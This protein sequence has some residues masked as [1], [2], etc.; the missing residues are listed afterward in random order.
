MLLY[1]DNVKMLTYSGTQLS[2]F[3]RGLFPLTVLHQTV[4]FVL[5]VD[6]TQYSF[7][8]YVFIVSIIET[9]KTDV[10]WAW[11]ATWKKTPIVH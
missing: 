1:D 6:F 5:S 11:F 8:F 2:E 4:I 3:Y 9:T 7:W 10:S